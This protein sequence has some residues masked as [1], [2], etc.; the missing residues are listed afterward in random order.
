MLLAWLP[1]NAPA[2][3]AL[4]AAIGVYC[5]RLLRTWALRTSRNAVTS[6]ELES[7]GRIVVVDRSGQRVEGRVR[8]ESYVGARLTTIVLRQD[9][10]RLARAIAIL[11]DMLPAADFRRLRVKLKFVELLR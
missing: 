1:G 4:V 10:R 9:R 11:P 5:V 8:P 7:D 3:A 6:I 2:R